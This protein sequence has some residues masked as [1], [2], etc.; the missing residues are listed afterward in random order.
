MEQYLHAKKWLEEQEQP[1]DEESLKALA[2]LKEVLEEFQSY[3]DEEERGLLCH[4]PCR[5]GERVYKIFQSPTPTVHQIRHEGQVYTR[6]SP[7][8]FV[9]PCPFD[10]S[11]MG[12]FG[13]TI[14]LSQDEAKDALVKVR[15]RKK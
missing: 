14:F 6:K 4:L 9:S 3:K 5:P 10:L 15:N 13:K 2:I 8:F 7:T 1:K 11:M 12:E